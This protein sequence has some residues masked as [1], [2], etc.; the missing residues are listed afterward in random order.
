MGQRLAPRHLRDL[1]SL[2]FRSLRYFWDIHTEHEPIFLF[3]D[4]MH[5]QSIKSKIMAV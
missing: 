1:A 5:R 2:E 3:A 4:L